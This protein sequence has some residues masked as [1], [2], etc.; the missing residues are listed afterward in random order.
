MADAPDKNLARLGLML[1]FNGGFVDTAGFLSLQGL[2]TA[3]VTGNFVTLGASLVHGTSGGLAKLVALPLFCVV[4]I[5]TRLLGAR[6]ERRPATVLPTLFTIMLVLLTLGAGL[7]GL[8]GPFADGNSAGA[9]WTGMVLVA[10]MAIQ[11]AVSRV[12]LAALPPSTLMTGTTTQVMVDLADLMRGVDGD[13]RALA[14]GRLRRMVPG[15][16]VFAIGCASGAGMYLLAR[17]WCFVLAP[18]VLLAMLTL[19]FRQRRLLPQPA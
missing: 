4:V 16:L 13:A 11:N 7:S 10:A 2:F 18:L 3:H 12:N 19:L 15:L 14:A 6:L 1:S 9:F 8:L 17:Q 5:C